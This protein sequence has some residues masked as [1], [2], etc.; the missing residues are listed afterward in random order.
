MKL[1][2]TTAELYALAPAEFVAARD[3]AARTARANG[4]KQLATAISRLRRPTV[5]AWAVNLLAHK[6]TQEL[7][8]LL[9]L[10]EALREAQR[11]L[12]ADRM[13]TLADQRRK[14]VNA[15]T[16]KAARL[17]SDAGKKLTEPVLREVAQTL[18][19]ALADPEVTDQVRAGVLTAAV[20]Y[21]G[22]GPAG[23]ALSAVPDERTEEPADTAAEEELAAAREALEAARAERDSTAADL[24]RQRSDV[25]ALDERI[26]ALRD[27][28]ARAEE[29]RRFAAAG[30]TSAEAALR[31][32]DTELERAQ[33]RVDE[34]D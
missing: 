25:A 26:T 32:A 14:A 6:A 34:L 3:E 18:N 30:V 11:T 29:S 27:E 5:A 13:R 24:E 19:A 1:E 15:L 7:G 2:Q 31:R 4:D 21:A 8:A 20:D 22:F 12:S 17:A 28:L 9:D 10:G 23:P 33:Q 16:D